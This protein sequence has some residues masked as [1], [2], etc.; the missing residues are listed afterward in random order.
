MQVEAVRHPSRLITT[1]GPF[2]NH[3]YAVMIRT[4]CTHVIDDSE[5]DMDICRVLVRS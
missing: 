4:Q 2:A 5:S 3:L 1:E